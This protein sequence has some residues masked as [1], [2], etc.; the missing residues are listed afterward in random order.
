MAQEIVPAGSF[1]PAYP[2]L[3][4]AKGGWEASQQLL[5]VVFKW[6]RL[7]FGVFLVFTGAAAI[8]MWL[9]SPVRSANA[10]ILIKADRMPLQISGLAVRTESRQLSQSMNSEAELIKSRLVLS[11]VARKLLSKEGKNVDQGDLEAKIAFLNNSLFTVPLRDSNVLQVTYFAETGKE[12]ESTLKLILDE[13]IDTQAAIQSGSNKLVEFYEQEKRRV[14]AELRAAENQL[15][16]W[17]GKNETVSINQQIAGHLSLLDDRRKTLQQTEAQ[18]EA[19]KAKV[20]I[21]Q[22]QL[23]SQPERLLMGQE[24]V[25]NPLAQKLKEQL[26]TT[27]ASLQDLLQRYTEKHR[28]VREKREQLAFLK[29]ELEAEEENMIGRQ[30]TGLNPLKE[31]LKQQLTD[32]QSLLSSLVSQKQTLERQVEDASTTLAGMREKKVKIDELS[33]LVDLHKDAFMLYGKKLEEGRIA[34]GLGKEQ[35]ANVAL[36]GPPH[37][38]RGTDLVNRFRIVVLAAI[39]SLALGMAVAFGFEFFN[40]AVRTRQDVEYYLGLPVLAAIPDLQSRALLDEPQAGNGD[41]T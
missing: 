3:P 21:V 22:N 41:P 7:I 26:V 16:E 25:K 19:T 24:Q 14:E 33:R 27:D 2:S 32:A 18:V 9:K 17:Q 35:L 28:S 8:A 1:P 38:G 13:Y 37:A 39:V 15:N 4:E 11:A 29:K 20:S 5:F 10:E 36:I 40:N 34:T 31:S 30:T 12:A 6:K 23:K